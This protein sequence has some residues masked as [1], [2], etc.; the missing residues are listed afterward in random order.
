MPAC[1]LGLISGFSTIFRISALSRVTISFGMP[2]GL[3]PA[4]TRCRS[5]HRPTASG[6]VGTGG[7]G[8]GG[9]G[10]RPQRVAVAS[11]GRS[12]CRANIIGRGC[13]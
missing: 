4:M 11:A 2:A 12:G 13:P 3:S 1:E 8:P 5:P 7:S 6:Q 10:E 9:D